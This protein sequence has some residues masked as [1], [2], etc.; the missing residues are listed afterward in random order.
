LTTKS[1]STLKFYNPLEASG[2]VTIEDGTIFDLTG[3]DFSK[4]NTLFT[5]AGIFD[6]KSGTSDTTV[7]ETLLSYNVGFEKVDNKLLATQGKRWV[8]P[9]TKSL[10]EGSIASLG[11]LKQNQ[12]W[13]TSVGYGL[14][15]EAAF[16]QNYTF[17]GFSGG[18]SRYNTGSHV[19]LDSYAVN[20]GIARSNGRFT[21]GALF[22][23]GW[24]NFDTFNQFAA[25][26]RG[27]GKTDSIG[28]SVFGKLNLQ[29]SFYVDSAAYF[30][31]A[32]TKFDVTFNGANLSYDYNSSY[33]GY[34]IGLGRVTKISNRLLMDASLRY[35][36]MFESGEQLTLAGQAVR[37]ASMDSQRLRF[38]T[39][40]QRYNRIA[41]YCDPCSMADEVT[42][43]AGGYVGAA[44][45]YEFSGDANG[46]VAG[47][48]IAS[49][50]YRGGTGIGELGVTGQ[51]GNLRYNLGVEGF[52]G[53]REGVSGNA[54]VTFNF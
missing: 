20:V 30:G 29:N 3:Y 23:G 40:I 22:Q 11:L 38:G 51:T 43:L 2:D 25:A 16:Q 37:F 26:V 53:K 18:S 13:L 46:T 44:W 34:H 19:D 27:K 42:R 15:G 36:G 39:R 41:A 14:L 54:G 1:D 52:L 9:E 4:G 24:G 12:D 21:L 10:L 28:G 5:V 35:F 31:S 7:K 50:S 8:N 33:G 6:Y 48:A 45:E 47:L 32:G 17:G 49:P